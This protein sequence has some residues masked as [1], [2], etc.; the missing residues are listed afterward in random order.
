MRRIES[1]AD[2]DEPAARAAALNLLAHREHSR[3][4]LRRK[5]MTRGCAE[6]VAEAVLNSLEDAGY[7]S[8]ARYAEIYVRVRAEKGYGPLRIRAELRE[9]GVDKALIEDCLAP[10]NAAWP[11]HL[12]RVHA[13]RFKRTE[14]FAERVRQARFFQTRGFTLEQIRAVL[15]GGKTRA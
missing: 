12:A 2:M 7:L 3:A 8:D 4:E 6:T 9:R 1:G 15:E 14:D 10:H 5:L 11:A 13:K